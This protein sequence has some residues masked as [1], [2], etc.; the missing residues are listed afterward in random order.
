MNIDEYRAIKAQMEKEATEEAQKPEQP[1]EVVD[2]PEETKAENVVE[3]ETVE[4]EPKED[5]PITVEIDG[6]E[7]TLDEL[8]N[9]YL[10]QSDYTRKTQELSRQRGEAKEAIEMYEYL[11]KNPQVVQQIQN[12]GGIVPDRVDPILSKY[13]ELE[14]KIYDMMLERDIEILQNKYD[15]FEVRDVLEIASQKGIT[16]LE[17]AYHLFKASK[18]QSQETMQQTVDMDKIKEDLRKEILK[19]L[20]EERD[21]TQT[22]I[23]TNSQTPV[24]N[25]QLP[26]ISKQ[27]VKVANM[28]GLSE[29]EYIRWRD[30][31]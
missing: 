25:V 1:T 9:G 24:A 14:D 28:M 23:S 16:N 7:V 12:N 20:S 13:K 3:V 15:D 11:K 26:K 29:E 31:K 27:E 21:S 30:A 4:E 10:R 2:V 8:R 6:E 5:K 17:D 19:E 18:P 22:I